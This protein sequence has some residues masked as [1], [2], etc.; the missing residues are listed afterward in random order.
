MNQID[1][2][3]RFHDVARLAE[4]ERCVFSLVGQEYRPLHVI[5]AT[6][7]FTDDQTRSTRERL[8]PLAAFSADIALTL[9]NWSGD[10]PRDARTV[11]LNLGLRTATGRYVAFLDYDDLLYPEA[12]ALLTKRMAAGG[13]AI[14]FAS[15]RTMGL[16]VHDR[17]LEVTGPVPSNFAG[18]SLHDLFRHNFC[19]IHSYLIDRQR[20]PPSVLAFDETLTQEEDYDLLLRICAAFPADFSLLGT[21]VGEYFYKTDGSNTVP[22]AWNR[23]DEAR[24]AG[25][26]RVMARIEARRRATM[27]TPAVQQLLGLGRPRDGISIHDVLAAATMPPPSADCR[28]PAPR[29][30]PRPLRRGVARAAAL[31][32]QP[33]RELRLWRLERQVAGSGL[34][35]AEWYA[36]TYGVGGVNPLRHFLRR[37]ARLGHRPNPHFDT[38]WYVAVHPGI[39]WTR[40]NPLAHYLE[41]SRFRHVDPGPWFDAGWYAE[42]HCDVA[43][44]GADPLGHYQC[45]G[46]REGRATQAVSVATAASARPLR[47]VKRPGKAGEVAIILASRGRH[48]GKHLLP[49]SAA[50]RSQGIAVVL[51]VPAELTD[52]AAAGLTGAVDG[53]YVRQDDDGDLIAWARVLHLH[54]E[55]FGARMLCLI[56]DSLVGPR[57]GTAFADLLRMLRAHSADVLGLTESNQPVWHLHSYFLAFKPGALGSFFLQEFLHNLAVHRCQDGVLAPAELRLMRLL[58]E[59]GLDCRSLFGSTA[60]NGDGPGPAAVPDV[61][62]GL[63]AARELPVVPALPASP[64]RLAFIGPWNMNNGQAVAG[65]AYIS[66]LRRTGMALNLHPVTRP[67]HIH[68]RI[69][70]SCE[71]CDFHGAADVAL[72]QV[73]ADGWDVFLTDEQR[74]IIAGARRSVG[75]WVWELAEIPQTW[76]PVFDQVDAIW[77]PSGFCAVNYRARARVPVDLVNYPV[78]VDGAVADPRRAAILRRQLGLAAG[79]RIILYVFDGASYLIRKNPAALVRAFAASCLAERGWRLVLKTKNLFDAAADGWALQRLAEDTG[80]VVLIDRSLDAETLGEL[81]RA[82]DIY[83]SPHCSEGF[84]LTIAEAMAMGKVVVATDF[85][86]SRDFVCPETAFTVRYDPQ[87]LDRDGPVYHQGAV[88][89]KVDERHLADCLLRAAGMVVG[90][91]DSLG[92]AARRHIEARLSPA[93]VAADIEDSLTRLLRHG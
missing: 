45:Y 7:R 56:S 84:G 31:I 59:V 82:S 6:Q 83:A 61:F 76:F 21:V 73:N 3:V 93:V 1:C 39:D 87:V 19:P 48:L 34:F 72:V 47:C 53:L 15:V 51:V 86:G 67:F 60:W 18:R 90:G 2:I 37:G 25:Y 91:D 14:A 62:G 17:F 11:L 49:L 30:W 16:A 41:V 71:V 57:D 12:Y 88:W 80:G 43:A 55:F 5:V 58:R 54:P 24:A 13:A 22:T 42:N 69:A 92:R 70:P 79:D 50:F 9:V 63:A 28:L 33:R 36:A 46:A 64:P 81:M 10:E 35:D 20:V 89:A 8:A 40:V 4:L 23:V 66:A 26:A 74:A 85:G 75:L 68:Q 38:T 32:C 27:V 65:R 29:A 44:A 78:A 77:A 52:Q